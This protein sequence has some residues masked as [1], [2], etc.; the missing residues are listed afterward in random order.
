MRGLRESSPTIRRCSNR[1]E[2]SSR[3]TDRHAGC[4]TWSGHAVTS[5]RLTPPCATFTF[6]ASRRAASASSRIESTA[7]M[8]PPQHSPASAQLIRQALALHRQGRLSEAEGLYA[9]VLARRPDD[10]DASYFLG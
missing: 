2:P 9:S 3:R 8:A 1:S 10:F 4:S 6:A 5:R 7:H